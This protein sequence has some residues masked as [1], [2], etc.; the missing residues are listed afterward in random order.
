MSLAVVRDVG[1]QFTDAAFEQATYSRSIVVRSMRVA[2]SWYRAVIVLRFSPVS[3]ATSAIR[4]LFCPISVERW[5]RII[6]DD[7]AA[8]VLRR[9]ASRC[10]ETSRG[11]DSQKGC[12]LFHS[13]T[14]RSVGRSPPRRARPD[15]NR[16]QMQL[17]ASD[18]EILL[19]E[20]PQR[21]GWRAVK[22]R[23]GRD[24]RVP[25]VSRNVP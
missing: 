19:A 6:A 9:I 16:A 15:A 12:E 5:Q 20:A 24:S 7:V 3:R 22:K 21:T 23:R 2:R 17:R 4:S 18:M 13:P 14:R 25:I 8:G 10:R 1:K 11:R